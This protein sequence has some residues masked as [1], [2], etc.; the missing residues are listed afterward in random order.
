VPSLRVARSAASV[1]A[2]EPGCVRQPVLAAIASHHRRR[3]P[4][5]APGATWPTISTI[6]SRSSRESSD[7][8]PSR[9]SMKLAGPPQSSGGQAPFALVQ[10]G[11]SCPA[12][13]VAALRYGLHGAKG[14]SGRTR[15]Q[16]ALACGAEAPPRTHPAK[17]P[18]GYPL[19]WEA[20]PALA[21]Q[22]ES[23]GNPPREPQSAVPAALSM[24][25]GPPPD[26]AKGLEAGAPHE[27][28]LCPVTT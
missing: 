25:P 5:C 1:R 26:D 9:P 12:S 23:G 14:C 21:Q 6:V 3:F 11:R 28:G 2:L 7:S 17:T 27:I 8:I 4:V 19:K 20:G 13:T 10:W 18:T 22:G 16:T 24:P 15:R